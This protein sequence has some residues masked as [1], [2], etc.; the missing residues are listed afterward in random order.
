VIHLL[1]MLNITFVNMDS[2]YL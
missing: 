1:K 2:K